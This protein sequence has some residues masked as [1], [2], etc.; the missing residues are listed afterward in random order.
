MFNCNTH[1]I[2][3]KNA[4]TDFPL[5][6]RFP[7]NMMF[8]FV[9]AWVKLLIRHNKYILRKV[10]RIR[11]SLSREFDEIHPEMYSDLMYINLTLEPNTVHEIYTWKSS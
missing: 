1:E 7:L 11:N 9:A 2:H 5:K 10:K 3:D 8:M 4:V 6:R